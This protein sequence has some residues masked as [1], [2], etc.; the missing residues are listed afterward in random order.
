MHKEIINRQYCLIVWQRDQSGSHI[1][2]VDGVSAQTILKMA[3]F[4]G[5]IKDSN[6][7]FRVLN[8]SCE[9]FNITTYYQ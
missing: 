1:L 2:N 6:G 7:E 3:D 8:F 5:L 9:N 4:D